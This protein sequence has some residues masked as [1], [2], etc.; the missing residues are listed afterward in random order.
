[1][2]TIIERRTL[3]GSNANGSHERRQFAESRDA[4]DPELRELAAAIDDY[5]LSRHSRFITL[6]EILQVAKSLGYRR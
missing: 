1:M 4:L 3:P 2:Q 5:K 6:G